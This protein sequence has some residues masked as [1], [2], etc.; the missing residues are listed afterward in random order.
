M[1]KLMRINSPKYP[2]IWSGK[3]KINGR[4]KNPLTIKNRLY[5]K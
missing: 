3:L 2:L 4:K 1:Q 5:V